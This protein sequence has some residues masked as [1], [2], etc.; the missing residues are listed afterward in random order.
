MTPE[1]RERLARAVAVI[2]ESQPNLAT[3]DEAMATAAIL[4]GEWLAS[5]LAL[6]SR[7]ELSEVL[8]AARAAGVDL[9][10]REQSPPARTVN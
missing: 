10:L 9:T 1:E 6:V 3:D 4:V 8:Q 2:R 7:A 5:G